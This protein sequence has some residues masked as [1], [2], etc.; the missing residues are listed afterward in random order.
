MNIIITFDVEVWCKNWQ[1]IDKDFPKA[2]EKYVYGKTRKGHYGLL[3]NIEII[4]RYGLKAV[5][6]VEPL[7]AAHFGLEPLAKI[8]QIIQD[9]DQEIHLHLHP[10]WTDEA[11]SPLLPNITNKR[12][13]LHYYNQTEQ[14]TLISHG[15]R[16]LREVG[17]DSVAAF[18]SGSFACN[19]DT[20]RS[21]KENKLVYDASLNATVPFSGTDFIENL[22]ATRQPF[23]FEGLNIFPMSVFRDGFGKMRHAQVAACSSNELKRSIESAYDKKWNYFT[24][25]SHNFELLKP[26]N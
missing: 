13:H 24:I 22:R 26:D 10:E 12:Q 11:I 16:M 8:V 7:F 17:A 1:M 3:I 15:L 18:R 23:V 2:F 6:F 25:L 21:I 5:F 19:I 4:N 14:S 20:F 9:A